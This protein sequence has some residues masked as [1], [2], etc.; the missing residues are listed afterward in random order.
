MN[1]TILYRW[2]LSNFLGGVVG[3]L[4]GL[5][6][7]YIIG[8]FSLVISAVMG[9]VV[10]LAQWQ[11]LSEYLAEMRALRWVGFTALGFAF[12]WT[13]FAYLGYAIAFTTSLETV[14]DPVQGWIDL[15]LSRGPLGPLEAMLALISTFPSGL[16]GAAVIGALTG[17][18]IGLSQVVVLRRHAKWAYRWLAAAAATGMAGTIAALY[19]SIGVYNGQDDFTALF[20]V[21]VA[22]S[23]V[24]ITILGS[25]VT[26]LALARLA[27]QKSPVQKPK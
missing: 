2:V 23:P 5:L 11:V 25:L 18:V 27:P 24:G 26:G 13:L 9:A 3:Y 21:S 20:I 14:G 16:L 15:S 4:T 6:F 22:L 10:G 12:G 1:W 8:D 19:L 17:A 7:A